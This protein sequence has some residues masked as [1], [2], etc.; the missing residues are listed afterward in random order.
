L[1]DSSVTLTG[2]AK[3]SKGVVACI[4]LLLGSSLNIGLGTYWD[5]DDEEEEDWE[6]IS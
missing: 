4:E 2:V 6:E 1:S 3:G 5:D